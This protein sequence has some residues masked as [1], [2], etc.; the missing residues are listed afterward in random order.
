[1]I[2][3]ELARMM[4]RYKAW[5]NEVFY[6]AVAALPEGEATRPRPTL[7]KNM[8]HTLNHLYVVERI[9]QGH[10]EGKDHGYTARNTPAHPPL[11]ELWRAVKALDRWYI[12]ASDGWSAAE[13]DEPIRF[14]FIGGGDG[15]MTRGEIV[16]HLVTHGSYH[17]GF[18]ADMMNQVSVN[19]PPADLTVF[20]RD[21]HRA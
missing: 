12:D 9:F 17:R 2:T 1:M 14:Q 16:L 4:T 18:V 8:V 3:P 19:P 11:D 10:L 5:A 15:V 13:V 21:V 7:F 6:A 20:L